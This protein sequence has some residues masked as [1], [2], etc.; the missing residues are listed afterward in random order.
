[1]LTFLI[2]RNY[3]SKE[4]LE[5]LKYG[6]VHPMLLIKRNPKKRSFEFDDCKTVSPTHKR[7]DEDQPGDFKK[8]SREFKQQVKFSLS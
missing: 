2:F 1:M 7:C 4:V 3:T 5:L 6:G 8:L